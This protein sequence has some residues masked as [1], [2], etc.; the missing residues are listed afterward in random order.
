VAKQASEVH[1]HVTAPP[2]WNEEPRKPVKF[3]WPKA[4][5]PQ[6]CWQ[7]KAAKANAAQGEEAKTITKD[8]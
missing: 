3:R 5:G 7:I 6:S 2:Q 8:W 1:N 4:R